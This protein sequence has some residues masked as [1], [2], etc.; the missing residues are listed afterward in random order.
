MGS[1]SG[2]IWRGLAI[3]RIRFHQLDPRSVRIVHIDL[4]FA[5]DAR[6]NYDFPRITTFAARL[7]NSSALCRHPECQRR[8]V[9]GPAPIRLWNFVVQHELQVVVAFGRPHVHPT[10][11]LGEPLGEPLPRQNSLK[12]SRP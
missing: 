4:A 10:E 12:P 11:H 3:H 8:M 9:L 5:I 1:R 6:L 2:G 7:F